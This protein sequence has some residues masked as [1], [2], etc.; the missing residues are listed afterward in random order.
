L[1]HPKHTWTKSEE[2]KQI[3]EM[4]PEALNTR[5]AF[6]GRKTDATN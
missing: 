5:D 4:F 6:L 3:Q 2:I 1:N